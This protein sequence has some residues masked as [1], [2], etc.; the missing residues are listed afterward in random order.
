MVVWEGI[1]LT[2]KMTKHCMINYGLANL[3][4]VERVLPSV[5]LLAGLAR[6]DGPAHLGQEPQAYPEAWGMERHFSATPVPVPFN[7]HRCNRDLCH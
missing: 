6:V 3:T 4:V 7:S 2:S 1:P 5:R